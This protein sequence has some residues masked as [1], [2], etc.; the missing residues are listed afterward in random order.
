MKI[1]FKLVTVCFIKS[2]KCIDKHL[3]PITGIITLSLVC[4]GD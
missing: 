2:I 4:K 1:Y 3:F